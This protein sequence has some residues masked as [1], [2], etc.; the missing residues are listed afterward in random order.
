MNDD[1]NRTGKSEF[2]RLDALRQPLIDR[3]ERFAEL[4]V[5]GMFP[6]DNYN[7]G[8]D[9]LTNGTTS[10]GS[11]GLTH[12][13]SRMMLTLF[14]P[15]RPFIRLELN[16]RAMAKLI[17]QLR[18]TEAQITEALSAG[19]R[20]AI[21]SLE[22]EGNRPALYEGLLH[23]AGTGNV[24][25]DL[26]SD[27]IRFINIRDYVVERD[28]RGRVVNLIFRDEYRLCDLDDAAQAAYRAQ[29]QGARYDTTVCM[30]TWVRRIKDMYRSTVYV[31]DQRL[32]LRFDGKY[33]PENLPWVALCWRLPLK[34]HYGVGRVEEYYSDLATHEQQAQALQDGAALAS[35]FRW[36]ANPGGMTRPEDIQKSDNGDVL[37]GT[38]NDLDLLFANIGQQLAT[39][40]QLQ[41]GYEK[42][43]GRGFLMNSAM[44]RDA[45]RVT[46]AEIRMQAIE[47]DTS[48]GGA[49]SRLAMDMQAPIARWLLRK[50]K[51]KVANTQVTPVILT[52]L[53][54][55]GRNAER[56]R[57]L[58]FISDVSAVDNLAPTTK[59]RL[60][61]SNIFADLAAGNGVQR[62]RY[63]A[64]ED[65]VRQRQEQ[66]RQDMLQAQAQQAGAAVAIEQATQGAPQQ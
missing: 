62:E 4:T 22:T 26:T 27:V 39:V 20:E 2:M 21:K 14:S 9:S 10:L 43:I 11:Q 34:Q 7:T 36:M 56:E 19:E 66:A 5:P 29:N 57:L 45:E 25:M 17:E 53:D 16:E 50:S 23:L 24:L 41:D 54:A 46:A 6:D 13:V 33:K 15:S 58:S 18:V 35:T 1:L 51:V 12:L 64:S 48:L 52:G 28:P 44:T 47:L 59:L 3:S 40:I 37:P 42:R 8:Q 65:E 55:L 38:T 32:P 30:Y 49:Y 63:V 31:E 61:E 60:Q